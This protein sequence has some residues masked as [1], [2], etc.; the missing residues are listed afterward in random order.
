[1]PRTRGAG[2][3]IDAHTRDAHD[4]VVR[5]GRHYTE[6]VNYVWYLSKHGK[7]EHGGPAEY[8]TR[9]GETVDV[10]AFLKR[11]WAARVPWVFKVILSP[12]VERSDGLPMEEFATAW[13][14][15][16]EADLGVVSTFTPRGGDW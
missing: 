2:A 8:F 9:E 16:V 11:L 7:G 14:Q 15:M 5:P 4:V 10:Q 1:M 3:P 6:V 13:M 12:A